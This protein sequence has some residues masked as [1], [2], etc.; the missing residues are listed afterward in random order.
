MANLKEWILNEADGEPIEG[1]VIGEV[2]WD[3]RKNL[4]PRYDEMPKGKLLSWEEAQDWL[5]YDFFN[6]Y[7][8]FGCTAV[9]AWTPTK[10]IAVYHYDGKV[11]PYSIPRHPTDGVMPRMEGGD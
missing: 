1:V 3:S 10:V 2:E 6:D 9:W 8:D 11:Y 5:D 4:V 7:G